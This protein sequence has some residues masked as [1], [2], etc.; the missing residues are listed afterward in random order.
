M[1]ELPNDIN[2]LKVLIKQLLEENAQIKVENAQLRRRLGMDSSNSDK[3]P[4]SDGYQKKPVKPGLPKDKN[5]SKGGQKGHKSNTLK[6]VEQPDR[7]QTHV[8]GQCQCCGR[9]F[10]PD[11]AQILQSR[12]V[13][14]WPEPK[15]EVTEH[16][17]GQVECCGICNYLPLSCQQDGTVRKQ[18]A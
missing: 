10:S 12:Q 3:P 5:G 17:I 2:K 9:Q 6:R 8:P 11:E 16:C 7:V 4:S 18:I 15:L 14:D 13:F 1:L